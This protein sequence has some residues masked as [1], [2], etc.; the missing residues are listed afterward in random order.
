MAKVTGPL[1]SMT[2]SGKIADA[3]V[4]FGW[5]GIAVV[6]Q[7]LVPANKKTEDQGDARLILGGLGRATKAA[8][9]TSLF[10]A[11]ALSAAGGVNTWGTAFVQYIRK[12]VLDTVD[13]Y[14]TDAAVFDA[15]L[16]KTV[17]NTGGT[18]LGLNDF[19]ISYAGTEISFAR[20]YMLYLLAK[21]AIAAHGVNPDLFDR[22]PY[23]TALAEWDADDVGDFIADLQAP[24]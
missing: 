5:K 17:F 24:V 13:H 18:T 11:D 3:M 16:Q 12:N 4:F 1:Y 9:A 20:G 15:H 21:Y 2:A 6:R 19:D 8:K 22:E 7:W 14:E 23:T 10:R